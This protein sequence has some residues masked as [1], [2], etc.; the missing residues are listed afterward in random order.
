MKKLLI[1]R[2]SIFPLLFMEDCYYHKTCDENN[3]KTN[4]IKITIGEAGIVLLLPSFLNKLQN[5][6]YLKF[7]KTTLNVAL[8]RTKK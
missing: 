6:L 2:S 7:V 8:I 1:N 3:N 5:K 4:K